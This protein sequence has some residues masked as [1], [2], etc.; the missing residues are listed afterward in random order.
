[1]K[2]WQIVRYGRPGEALECVEVP[3]PS[4]PGPGLVTVRVA[5]VS[6]NWNDIDMCYGRYPTI[7]PELPFTLGMDLCGVVETT[8]PGLETWLG[9]RIVSTGLGGFGALAS[10]SHA[11]ADSLFEAPRGLDDAEA[12]AFFIPF[13]TMHLALHR[14]ARLVAGE[15]LLVHAAAGGLGTAALQLGVA[16]GARVI[17]TVGSPEKE[18]LCRELGADVVIDYRREDFVPR[19][20]EA[21]S[22]RGVDVVCDLVGGPVAEPSWRCV[23]HEGRYLVAG[24]SSGIEA[25]ETGLPPRPVAKGNFS[26]VGVMMAYQSQPI[27]GL[28]DAGFSPFP[29]EVGEGVH[30]DLCRLLDAGRIRP[31]VGRRVGF[32]E[33]PA[34]YAELESRRTIGRTVVSLGDDPP[35]S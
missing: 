11:P 7:Q 10:R 4:P 34:A 19:V 12:A 23:A 35:Q 18:A 31:I 8:G 22:G 15:T 28:R 26:L 29:R 33:V 14:R 32:E 24:F 2:A 3:E 17:A 20:L 9:R 16:A 21:T 5:A 30:A 27:P 6:L 1:M 25:G 13:H